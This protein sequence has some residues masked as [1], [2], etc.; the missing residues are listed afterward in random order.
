MRSNLEIYRTRHTVETKGHRVLL[1]SVYK[2]AL[3]G[4]RIYERSVQERMNSKFRV[5]VPKTE[6]ST[7]VMDRVSFSH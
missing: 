2:S 4:R 7:T 6:L 3:V 5:G 1:L